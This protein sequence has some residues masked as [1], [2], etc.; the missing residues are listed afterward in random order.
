M[1]WPIWII[2]A[3]FVSVVAF[4]SG[5]NQKAEC[6]AIILIGLFAVQISKEIFSVPA[7]WVSATLIWICAA[8][9]VV[10]IRRQV[11]GQTTGIAVLL[12]LSG[13]CIPF[14]RFAGEDYA[15]GSAAL[16]FSDLFGAGALFWLGGSVVVGIG[17]NII[18][19][20]H[21]LGGSHRAG[22]LGNSVF[23]GPK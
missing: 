13:L 21:R 15:L 18:S 12:L 6:S 3:A 5:Q 10:A 20:S 11:S 17:R 22:I 8:I 7:V 9:T 2:M 16:F 1:I 19:R 4:L 23:G 14:G